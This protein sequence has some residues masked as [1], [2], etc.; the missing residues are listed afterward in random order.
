M[1][2]DSVSLFRLPSFSHNHRSLSVASSVC[3]RNCP[4]ITFSFQLAF[5]FCLFFLLS[6]FS[7]SSSSFSVSPLAATS[8][9]S[10]LSLTYFFRPIMARLTVSSTL[11]SPLPPSLLGIYNL[12]TLLLGWSPLCMVKSFLVLRSISSSSALVQLRK[13]A[14]YLHTGIAHVLIPL[15]TIPHSILYPKSFSLFSYILNE[16]ELPTDY[17]FTIGIKNL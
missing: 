5:L 3:P 2:R 8:S 16:E 10:M 4:C 12:S 6:S 17:S 1:M 7:V 14:E 13:A 11:M 9:F 15:M